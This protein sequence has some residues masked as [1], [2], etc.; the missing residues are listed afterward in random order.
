MV[1]AVATS[2]TYTHYLYSTAGPDHS[3]LLHHSARP[4]AGEQNIPVKITQTSTSTDGSSHGGG[5]FKVSLDLHKLSVEK[6]LEDRKQDVSLPAD[7]EIK[8]S[9]R[10]LTSKYNIYIRERGSRTSSVS[11]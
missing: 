7:I 10:R 2:T 6:S 9:H 1:L 11:L 3:Q 8:L 4:G 5:R